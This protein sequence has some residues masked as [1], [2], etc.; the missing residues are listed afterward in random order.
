MLPFWRGARLGWT[1]VAQKED[2]W[3]LAGHGT[4]ERGEGS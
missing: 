2:W 1:A 3:G 4:A